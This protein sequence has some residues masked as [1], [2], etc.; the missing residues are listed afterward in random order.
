MRIFVREGKGNKEMSRKFRGKF[1]SYM[2]AEEIKFYGKN[3][4]LENP[5]IYNSLIQSLYDK[6]GEIIKIKTK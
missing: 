2:R 4:Y 3:K 6:N 1:L 5:E